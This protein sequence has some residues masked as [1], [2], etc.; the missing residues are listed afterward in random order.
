[1]PSRSPLDLLFA[2]VGWFL[3]LLVP[4]SVAA[5]AVSLP[6]VLVGVNE[7]ALVAT[8]AAP[9][10]AWYWW[11]GRPV[12]FLGAWFFWTVALTLA[13]GLVVMIVLGAFDAAP[14]T[15]SDPARALGVGFV[16]VVYAL[17][18]GVASRRGGAVNPKR[19]GRDAGSE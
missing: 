19:E 4:V 2:L 8:L 16:A 18:Y 1:M 11:A 10:A 5:D 17:A 6:A 15:G 9:V 3:L 13:F 12:G 7:L 14:T